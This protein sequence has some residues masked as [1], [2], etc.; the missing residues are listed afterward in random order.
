VVVCDMAHL[1]LD[2]EALD[3]AIVLLII[4]NYFVS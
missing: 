1:P 3:V 4:A 2:D